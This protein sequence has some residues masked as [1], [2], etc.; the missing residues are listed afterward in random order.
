MNHVINKKLLFLNSVDDIEKINIKNNEGDCLL[1]CV[2]MKKSSPQL[3]GEPQ[4]N[5]FQIQI[6]C[7]STVW[8]KKLTFYILG[9]SIT[10][11]CCVL[12][13]VVMKKKFTPE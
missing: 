7:F 11:G 9:L 8:M 1:L 3:R 5:Y 6:C 13:C 2:V 4:I 10:R 12:L